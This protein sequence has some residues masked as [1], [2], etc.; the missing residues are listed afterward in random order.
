[1]QVELTDLA[2]TFDRQ[3]W[4]FRNVNYQF[5]TGQIYG[6]TGPSG[7]G[8]STLLNIISKMLQPTNGSVILLNIEAIR[9]IFQNPVG[10]PNRTVLDHIVLPLIGQGQTRSFAENQATQLLV[11]FNMLELAQQKYFELSG[12]Q[13]QR[14]M[15][16]N[17]IAS[18]PDLLLID[19]PTA[20]LDYES[21]L[22][23]I[24]ILRH[25]TQ[26]DLIVIIAS[27]DELAIN[28]SDQVLNLHNFV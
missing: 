10:I 17:A 20:Q 19:E 2:H 6:I 25:L 11:E 5:K 7:S 3:H 8:K 15:L 27:H 4:L 24:N 22:E 13:A 1:L 26:Q 9:W 16:I 12:G 23:V 18:K 28:Q 14:L 21:S